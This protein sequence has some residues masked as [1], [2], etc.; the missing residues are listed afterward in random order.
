MALSRFRVSQASFYLVFCQD[1]I[2][3]VLV[4]AD[5]RRAVLK[6]S[7]SETDT[8]KD[9]TVFLEHC[10]RALLFARYT[11]TIAIVPNPH[12]IRTN[13]HVTRNFFNA[14]CI[15]SALNISRTIYGTYPPHFLRRETKEAP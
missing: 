8:L 1:T 3:L 9:S 2:P 11:S 4:I 5:I 13:E 7:K 15:H 12:Y 6:P 10:S 14:A